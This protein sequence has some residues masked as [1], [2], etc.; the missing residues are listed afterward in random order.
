MRKTD[1]VINCSGKEKQGEVR[2]RGMLYAMLN[3]FSRVQVFV[4][5]W[6]VAHQVPLSMGFSKQ[7]YW[8]GLPCPSPRG[9][10]DSGMKPS[11]LMSPALAGE[12]FITSA[13]WEARRLYSEVKSLSRVWLTATPWPAAYQAPPSMGFSRQEYWSGCH[14]LRMLYKHD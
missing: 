2:E 1:R 5:P 7:E 12:F 10:L 4:T 8:S 14:C 13:I 6:T 9:L 11:S 3:H